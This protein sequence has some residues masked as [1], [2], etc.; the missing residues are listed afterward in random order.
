MSNY[1]G[2][3]PIFGLD[4]SDPNTPGF[5]GALTR[6][7]QDF[8]KT[9]NKTQQTIEGNGLQDREVLNRLIEA[10][11]QGNQFQT[12]ALITDWERSY[13]AYRNEHFVG[14]KYLSTDF[15]GRSKLFRP[16]TRS[17]VR[18]KMT[19][20]ANALFANP[21]A[22]TVEAQDQ[23]NPMQR[24]SAA[25]KKELLN[26][27]L[28]R[29]SRRNG[30]RWFLTSMGACQQGTLTGVIISKQYWRYQE[31]DDGEVVEDRPASDLF[32]PENVII[33]PNADWMD[34]AQTA[35]Y[36]ILRHPMN[37]EMAMQ[38]I[39]GAKN[40]FDWYPV[41]KEMLSGGTASGSQNSTSGPRNA[42]TG[43]VDPK[44]TST[45]TYQTVWLFEV[46]M[47]IGGKDYTFWTLETTRLL[48]TPKLVKQAHP[49]FKGERP[50]V[51]GYGALEAH[52]PF[53]MSPA[54]SWQMLQMEINDMVNLRLDHM[55]ML[56]NR[57]M[58]IKRG[59][60][61]DVQAVQRR[62]PASVIYVN[63]H[64]DIQAEEIPDVPQSAYVETNYANAD[65]DDL[66]GI[67]NAGSVQTNRSMNETVGGMKLLSGDASSIGEFD[68]AV[69]TETWVEPVLYQLLKLEETYESDETILA[70]CGQNARL[71][72]VY[73]INTITDQLL[74]ME[75]SVMVNAGIG[76][77]SHP[78]EKVNRFLTAAQG[79]GAIVGPAAQAGAAKMPTLKVG[80]IIDTIFGGAG[81]RNA[82]TRFF[83]GIDDAKDAQM[84]QQQKEQGPPPDPEKQAKA[85]AIQQ[86]AQ[87]DQQL[88][89]LKM[90]IEQERG[91]LE[92]MLKQIK[93]A[94]EQK[95]ADLERQL[96]M[97]QAQ[98]EQ[99]IRQKEADL[100]AQMAER[101]NRT[102]ANIRKFEASS[103]AM[104]RSTA[105]RA[106]GAQPDASS[107]PAPQPSSIDT[108]GPQILD[109][110]QQ[111]S[112]QIAAMGIPQQPENGL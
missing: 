65:F 96:K 51:I 44:Q 60:K 6:P 64:D 7:A 63:G 79:V 88:A 86:K 110:L 87:A 104:Q 75:A 52:N 5:Q 55:K 35:Q 89:M 106:S 48:C 26:Y 49:A 58:Q 37:A 16:R 68:M 99:D 97:Q 109:A 93:I 69:F 20:A 94:Q 4:S 32:A 18:K 81:F 17:A 102:N 30:I 82:S 33:D 85:Q 2:L 59:A 84:L 31:D 13:R 27:R 66:A 19:A 92:I 57:P 23:T 43:M 95:N 107:A 78:S 50:I 8:A 29:K 111:L 22:V 103:R 62:G 36:I 41:T 34:P 98:M 21:D 76:A 56:V 70:V 90:Q 38:M 101:D 28:S 39:E 11:N 74:T 40:S 1:T 24:G 67:F 47:R 112:R 108:M 91:K 61:V 45:G 3:S 71:I 77:A 53:P 46:F 54:T 15:K 100:N 72:E 83:E 25:L 10:F 105:P 73:G 42:R 9:A 80:E 12:S 14:S